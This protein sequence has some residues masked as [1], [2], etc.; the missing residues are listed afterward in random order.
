LQANYADHPAPIALKTN[1]N[2]PMF[3]INCL[4]LICLAIAW[5]GC[6]SN[7]TPHLPFSEEDEAVQI[8]R[9][10]SEIFDAVEKKDLDRLDS[11]HFYGE[12]FSKFAANQSGRQNS[13]AARQA[14]HDGMAEVEDLSIKAEDLKIDV[15][16]DVGIAT[17]ILHYS[18]RTGTNTLAGS[19]RATLVFVRSGGEWKITHEHLSEF[20]PQP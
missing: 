18:F 2:D 1:A 15:F 11:Y 13:N 6:A 9:R 5:S 20:K 12:A 8:K 17:F 10:L 4:V 14:E 16:R 19:D 3:K 7:T